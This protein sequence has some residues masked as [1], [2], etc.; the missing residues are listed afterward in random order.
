MRIFPLEYNNFAENP[1]DMKLYDVANNTKPALLGFPQVMAGMFK[2]SGSLHHFAMIDITGRVYVWGDNVCNIAGKGGP[3]N[4]PLGPTATDVTDAKEVYAYANG[5]DGPSVGAGLGYGV[6]VLTNAGKIILLGNTQ[7]GF[8]GD[9]TEGNN[10]ETSPYT[11][12]LSKQVIHMQVGTAIYALFVDGTVM[13]W[14]S[15]RL[16]YYPTYLLGQGVD[17]PNASIPAQMTFPETI[18]DIVGGGQFTY[19]VGT[20]GKLYGVAYNT[21][22]LGVGANIQ[23][24]NKPFTLPLTFP[25]KIKQLLV[26]PQASYALMPNGDL[27]AWGDNSEAAIGNG[28]EGPTAQKTGVAPWNGGEL[29]VDTPVK[30]NPPGVAFAQIFTSIGDAFYVF[31]V[32]VN[33]VL[34]S[35]GRNKSWVLWNYKGSTDSN[36]QAATPNAW[37]VLA[38]TK[39]AGFGPVTV[40]P[41]PVV[42]P[43]APRLAASVTATINGTTY[44]IPMAWLKIVYNDG[45]TQ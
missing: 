25:D 3:T 31:A 33:G 15:S 7:S 29:W 39:I 34:Y 26:G 38:P 2:A 21:R 41:P 1:S 13:S 32:D 10:A 43:P 36:V 22:Y 5:G 44:T 17:N 18:V 42:T 40:T 11:V 6:A 45:S 14:G 12:Q 23:G 37:D 20:S 8:R 16:K 27:Y 9:G 4:A 19:F 28:S 24:Q 35:W 30:V